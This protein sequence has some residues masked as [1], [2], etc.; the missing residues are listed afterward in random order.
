MGTVSFVASPAA[1]QVSTGTTANCT[2]PATVNA[3]DLLVVHVGVKPETSPPSSTPP[4]GW[5]YLAAASGIGGFGTTGSDTGKMA[6]GIYWKIADGTEAGATVNFDVPN[7]ANVAIAHSICFAKDSAVWSI[8]GAF[9]DRTTGGSPFTATATSDPGVDTG[10]IVF[11]GVAMPTDVTLPRFSAE[12]LTQTGVTFGAFVETHDLGT[13]TSTDMSTLDG[14]SPVTGGPSSAADLLITA[15]V[16]GTT[17]NVAGPVSFVRIRT[18]PITPAVVAAT[19][20]ISDIPPGAALITPATVQATTTIGEPSRELAVASAATMAGITATAA[21][22]EA[23]DSWSVTIDSPV[24]TALV[25]PGGMTVLVTLL[26]GDN[27]DAQVQVDVSTSSGFGTLVDTALSEPIRDGDQVALTISGLTAGVTY[28]IRARGGRDDWDQWGDWSAAISVTADASIG[29]GYV[30][31]YASD[32]DT[33][34]PTPHV[35]WTNYNAITGV[36]TVVGAGFGA[37][38]GTY[39]GTIEAV[40][41]GGTPTLTVTSWTQ[42]ADAAAGA[43][44]AIV[45]LVSSTAQTNTVVAS[46]PS[47]VDENGIG[48][49]VS[50]N[51]GA[52]TSLS[53]VSIPPDA[54]ADRPLTGW[55]VDIRDFFTPS[56]I[57]YSVHTFQ[58]LSFTRP[59]NDTG[60][61]QVTFSRQDPILD[62]IIATDDPDEGQA[63]LTFPS[64]WSFMYDG[65]ERFRMVYE[66]KAKDR[67]K[68][69]E[70]ENV[71]IT[72]SG[73][74]VELGWAIVLPRDWPT[75]T[76]ARRRRHQDS[77]WAAL[78]V[79]LFDE[80]KARGEIERLSLSFTATHDSYGQPWTILGDREIEV[81]TTLLDVLQTAADVEEFDWVVTPKGKIHAAPEL[82]QDLSDTIRFFPAVNVNEASN[83]ED[84][85]DIRNRI[86]VEGTA[87]R[88]SVVDGEVSQARWGMRAMY[89]RSEEA[90]SERQ[91]L[92]VARGTLRQTRRPSREKTARVPIEHLDPITGQ[93]YGKRLFIDYG[94]GDT[95]GLGT[96]IDLE[97]DPRPSRD[98]KVQEVAVNVQDGQTDVELVFEARA[99]RLLERARRILQQRFGAWSSSKTARVGKVPVANLRDTDAEFPAGGDSL[100]YDPD[101]D[102]GDGLWKSGRALIPL[103]FWYQGSLRA[104]SSQM[105]LPIDGTRKIRRITARFGTA[106]T[107]GP[108]VLELRRNGHLIHT[109]SV[110]AGNT[111]KREGQLSIPITEDDDL[112]VDIADPGT[113][114]ANLQYVVE[115]G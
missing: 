101:A 3:A 28:W 32:V 38:Q 39:S 6:A 88:I 31:L 7:G 98:V 17:T 19:T 48:S 18:G 93:S 66:G 96:K 11:I 100:V 36:V 33:S 53:V 40:Y 22:D 69:G 79:L 107:S 73:R 57:L 37:T 76:K 44:R 24:D 47:G 115:A 99:E 74:A 30:Y 94:L 71:T 1:G 9:G 56:T 14:Y 35:W 20:T 83:I 68:A 8:G 46:A 16:G 60:Y 52:Q 102:L 5:N 50:L 41:V 29:E 91:R 21:V 78:F 75:N 103:V 25:T 97:G 58:Q 45:Y 34:Q 112:S 63:L 23:R 2:M 72:G 10:D 62:V 108:V 105:F 80:A 12:V 59:L 77:P 54:P 26:S 51:G 55:W 95:I 87:G 4:A 42:A 106:S 27:T 67:A 82:G 86:Y 61:G 111:R 43:G 109:L 64:Y 104:V 65:A 90:S 114:A 113:G 70:P 110:A 89:L 85:R 49:Q 15:T 13:S 81:G 92:R 84:R